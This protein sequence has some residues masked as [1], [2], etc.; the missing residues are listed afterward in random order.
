M[1]YSL[2]FLVFLDVDECLLNIHD[3]SPNADCTN[4]LGSYNCKCHNGYSGDGTI[5][6]KGGY[7]LFRPAVAVA[8]NAT[9]VRLQ[10]LYRL[11][12]KIQNHSKV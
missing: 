8:V 2:F 12:S 1:A 3:C 9:V 5:C 7:M 11:I 6:D 4:N 10:E